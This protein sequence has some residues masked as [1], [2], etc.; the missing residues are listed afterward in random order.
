MFKILTFLIGLVFSGTALAGT[1]TQQSYVPRTAHIYTP[2]GAAANSPALIVFHPAAS[3]ALLFRDW[4]GIEAVADAKGFRVAYLEGT[5][6]PGFPNLR[7][8]NAGD[9]CGA[10]K[11]ANADDLAFAEAVIGSLGASKVA[12]FGF[13]NGAMM[14]YRIA[15]QRPD[16]ADSFAVMAGALVVPQASCAAGIS[17][18]FVHIHGLAD[19]TVPFAGGVGGEGVTYPA[20]QSSAALFISAGSRFTVFDLAGTPHAFADEES[21]LAAQYGQSVQ[22]LIGDLF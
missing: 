7:T 14:A 21:A 8:W 11:T 13:S 16:L 19:T 22:S 3:N 1:L 15:C 5:P 6:A 4:L 9:C 18:P 10:A 2:T 17:K 12:V 20:F